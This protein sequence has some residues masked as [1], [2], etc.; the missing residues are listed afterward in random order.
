ML[1]ITRFAPAV[2]RRLAVQQQGFAHI[3]CLADL[4]A[5]KWPSL[6]PWRQCPTCKQNYVD[7]VHLALSK[8]LWEVAQDKSAD[9]RRAAAGQLGLALFANSDFGEAAA[10]HRETLASCLEALGPSEPEMMALRAEGKASEAEMLYTEAVEVMKRVFGPEDPDTLATASNLGLALLEQDQNGTMAAN[11]AMALEAQKRCWAKTPPEDADLAHAV[12]L[13]QERLRAWSGLLWFARLQVL[14]QVCGRCHEESL[15]ATEETSRALCAFG[16]T[17]GAIELQKRTLQEVRADLGRD[18]P[19]ALAFQKSLAHTFLDVGLAE[20]ASQLLRR[21]LVAEQANGAEPLQVELPRY[22]QWNR[23]GTDMEQFQRFQ[24][25]T[26]FQACPPGSSLQQ[27]CLKPVSAMETDSLREYFET[28]YREGGVFKS[29]EYK[30]DDDFTQAWKHIRTGIFVWKDAIDLSTKP[31]PK[32]FFHYTGELPYR[33]ITAIQKE[34]A[35]IWASLKTEGPG[36]NAWWGRGVYSVPKPPNEWKN[37]QELLDN[38]FRNMMKRDLADPNKGEAFV[39][40]EYPP[41]AA[42][43]IPLLIDAEHAYDVSVRATPEMEAAGK[44]PGRNLADKLLN[45]PGHPER[46]CVVLRVEGEQG[47]E[48]AKGRLVDTLRQREANAQDGTAKTGA[49]LRLGSALYQRGFHEEAL[50]YL[51]DAFRDLEF[52]KG[53]EDPQTLQALHTLA[54]C[55]AQ[56]RRLSEAEPL[57]QRCLEVKARTLGAEHRST[58]ASMNC[59]ALVLDGYYRHS[60][61]EQLH[62]RCLETISKIF[63]PEHVDALAAETNLALDTVAQLFNVAINFCYLQRLPEAEPLL[64]RAFAIQAKI[65]GEDHPD[66]LKTVQSLAQCLTRMQR[67]ADAEFWFR[68]TLVSRE[69]THSSDHPEVVSALEG[70]AI[71]LGKLCRLEEAEVFFRRAHDILHRTLG[72][73][74]PHRRDALRNLG[75]CLHRMGRAQEAEECQKEIAEILE[76]ERE[77]LKAKVHAERAKFYAAIAETPQPTMAPWSEVEAIFHRCLGAEGLRLKESYIKLLTSIGEHHGPHI[78]VN[79]FLELIC[80]KA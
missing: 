48:N 27:I 26:P 36:A 11:L 78:S 1:G 70:L 8:A 54:I 64:Q 55:L 23:Y 42:F 72:K 39:N 77:A 15:M 14:R 65:L 57:F 4:A 73:L 10:I 19:Y 49:K 50:G 69:R 80:P 75:M 53:K 40:K 59:F 13:H 30:E 16:A 45:E 7:H 41:R 32:C 28:L 24:K 61:A 68:Q 34:A 74:H 21:T 35:E 71:C 2:V 44:P 29:S 37:R 17:D 22:M 9:V 20:Q 63:G 60:E 5:S 76:V 51:Q 58:L 46:C 6:E 62:R 52:S 66:T 31:N 18:H 12:K 25:Q 67:L 47:I 43:C 3:Q 38:N 33:N 56:M 79:A